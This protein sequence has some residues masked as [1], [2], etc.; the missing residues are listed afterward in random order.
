MNVKEKKRELARKFN[1]RCYVCHRAFGKGFLFHHI[2]Y[3][4]G[5]PKQGTNEYYE[6]V[7]NQIETH[8][9]QF[10]LLCRA[11]HYFVSWRVS[12]KNR[13]LWRRFLKVC[14]DTINGKKS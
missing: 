14:T 3:D 9:E 11:H 7:F 4:G 10:Y 13:G 5:E 12:I 2:Y 8:P 1:S 6:Y